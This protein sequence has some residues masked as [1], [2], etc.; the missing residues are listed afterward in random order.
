MDAVRDPAKL[1]K[2]F[3]DIV[4]GLDEM[5]PKIWLKITVTILKRTDRVQVA[6]EHDR[7]EMLGDLIGNITAEDLGLIGAGGVRKAVGGAAG[8]FR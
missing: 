4:E 2:C 5:T 3:R 7:A 1:M 6:S 8:K